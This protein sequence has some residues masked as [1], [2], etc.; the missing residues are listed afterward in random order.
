MAQG[1]KAQALTVCVVATQF[2]VVA[3]HAQLGF[4]SMMIGWGYLMAGLARLDR[5]DEP[6]PSPR[7]FAA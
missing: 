5:E 1:V 2:A 3:G 6:V 4:L 7:G